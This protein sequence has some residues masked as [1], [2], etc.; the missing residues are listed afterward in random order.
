[1]DNCSHLHWRCP[2]FFWFNHSPMKLHLEGWLRFLSLHCQANAWKVPAPKP[3]ALRKAELGWLGA[4]GV[5]VC[6]CLL[7]LWG[8][9]EMARTQFSGEFQGLEGEKILVPVFSA[10]L[11]TPQLS[12]RLLNNPSPFHLCGG[13][14]LSQ[15][16]RVLNA[17]SKPCLLQRSSV[18]GL[19][20]WRPQ[21]GFLS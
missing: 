7:G 4:R 12:A 9:Y 2:H 1:M 11:P 18:W 13:G 21:S 17:F 10:S 15:L 14:N 19:G 16:K 6:V 3:L 5:C 8:R 20:V